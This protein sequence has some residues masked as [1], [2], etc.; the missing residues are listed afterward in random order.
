MKK[1]FQ[2][3]E[4][5]LRSARPSAGAASAATAGASAT[6]SATATEPGLE[7]LEALVS[8]ADVQRVEV[9]AAGLPRMVEEAGKSASVRPKPASRMLS[10]WAWLARLDARVLPMPQGPDD[11]FL[12]AQAFIAQNGSELVEAVAGSIDAGAWAGAWVEKA[13]RLKDSYEGSATGLGAAGREETARSLL[14]DLDD[15]EL[16][17]Y[18][19]RLFGQPE[20]E[21]AGAVAACG[22]WLADHADAFLSCGPIVRADLAM[23]RRDLPTADPDLARTIEKLVRVRDAVEEMEAELDFVTTE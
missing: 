1:R 17:G 10:S 9:C 3:H 21:L 20:P 22:R 23:M 8:I 19:C 18:A 12:Q 14:R 11:P 13:R 7:P 4:S 15:L 16:T 6:T 5:A 2:L